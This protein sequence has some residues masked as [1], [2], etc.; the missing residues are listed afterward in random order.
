MNLLLAKFLIPHSENNHHP[1]LIRHNFLSLFCFTLILIQFLGNFFFYGQ[2]KVLGYATNIV[3]S[4]LIDLTNQERIKNGL[5]PLRENPNLSQAA[6]FKGKDM[7]ENNYWAHISPSGMTPWNFFLKV[8]Y[9]YEYAGENLAKDFATSAGVVNGW[10]TSAS[11]RDN[12]LS[13]NYQE[14]GMAVQNGVLLGKETTLVVQFFGSP[15]VK[16]AESTFFGTPKN[17]S[18]EVAS[19]LKPTVLPS[20]NPTLELNVEAR[21]LLTKINSLS[22]SKM[23]T[24]VLIL[25]LGL[26]FMI[27]TLVLWK[28]RI[29]R[30]NSHSF[31]HALVLFILVVLI[32]SSGGTVL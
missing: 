15:F 24:L 28:K 16:S 1:H 26:V 4:E 25:I 22:T 18:G 21:T 32:L 5:K 7:F 10:V 11:H 20:A 31:L 8:D 13:P 30:N 17:I 9:N 2:A 6:A 29:R 27:D 12:I 23:L 3:Q 14:I 19:A